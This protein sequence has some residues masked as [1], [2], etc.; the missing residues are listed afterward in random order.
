MGLT[1]SNPYYP[2]ANVTEHVLLTL[3][4]PCLDPPIR[5]LTTVIYSLIFFVGL[6]GNLCTCLV[7]VKN[8]YMKTATNYY[9]CS[10]AISDLT[11][12]VLGLPVELYQTWTGFYPFS[13]PGFVCKL[14]GFVSEWMIYCSILTIAG[15]SV[16][17][18]LAI[19]FPLKVQ[20]FSRLSR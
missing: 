15:F 18:W 8:S 19:C 5:H 12:L 1:C 10:L 16:E 7:I 13:I 4:P 2:D 17:R 11:S 3:G 6:V 14:R 20:K 9:L